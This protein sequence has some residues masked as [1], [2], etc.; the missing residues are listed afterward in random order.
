MPTDIFKQI[1]LLHVIG[2]S[3]EIL[4]KSLENLNFKEKIEQKKSS[5]MAKCQY[6]TGI[7]T[8]QVR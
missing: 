6:C 5:F 3:L 4:G 8:E 1:T 7:F 2:L